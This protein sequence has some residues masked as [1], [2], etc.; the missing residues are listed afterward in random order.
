MT[1]CNETRLDVIWPKPDPKPNRRTLLKAAG[2]LAGAAAVARPHIAKAQQ[3]VTLAFCSQLLCVT[4]YEVTRFH[5][6]FEDEGLEV[7][8]VYTRGGN[9]AMQALVGGAVDYAATSFD[10]AVQ[11]FANGGDIR[12]F[13]TT[14]RLPLFALAVAPGQVDAITSLT[15][16]EGRTVGVSALGNADHTLTLFLL[17]QA[18]VD[19][20]AV[21]F[22][23]LGPN[24]YEALR[25]GQVDA[26]MV[27]EPA[28]SLLV[29]EGGRVLFNA[30]D[31][32]DAEAH[33][34]GPYEFM[35][36]AYRAGE[37]EE[38]LE[39]MQAVARAL[40]AGLRY[41]REAPIERLRE[42]L[43]SELLVGGDGERFDE[44][45][46]RYRG[47]LYPTDVSIDRASCERVINAL[48][49]GGSLKT[50]VDLDQLLDQEVVPA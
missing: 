22:A 32:D 30:M 26:G 38:R 2:S 36:V 15:G 31:L 11:A 16:L 39:Q 3:Q 12:R 20:S 29:E 50:D 9:A 1:C 49:S 24:L 41:Q 42:S 4:P 5:G 13:A 27:Q 43:P 18:G 6:F 40:E 48:R 33:L 28:L 25:R 14:G 21:S 47:S 45:I 10:V 46:A 17:A 8:L 34:G 19:S 7:E 37:R 44:I 23:V 35:G